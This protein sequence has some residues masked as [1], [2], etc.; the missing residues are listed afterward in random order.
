MSVKNIFENK[1]HI[2]QVRQGNTS[3]TTASTT[4]TAIAINIID[5][6]ILA[7]MNPFTTSNIIIITIIK[8]LVTKILPLVLTILHILR[9]IK[10]FLY[11]I[12]HHHCHNNNK[13]NGD[14]VL[15][16]IAI[17]GLTIG[18]GSILKGL[19]NMSYGIHYYLS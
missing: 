5:A 1:N 15:L 12:Y 9:Y 4:N 11:F 10:N 16:G 7:T 14:N 18:T 19:Y 8:V 6:S 13:E 17:L 2:A 3:T